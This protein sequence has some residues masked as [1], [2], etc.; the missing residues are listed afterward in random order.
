[1]ND[2]ML[3]SQKSHPA[4]QRISDLAKHSS[5]PGKLA[6]I[7]DPIPL[8]QA[9]K[10]GLHFVGVYLSEGLS[11]PAE[12][13]QL[14][15]KAG[16]QPQPI[17]AELT[18]ELFRSDKRPDIFGIAKTPP[19]VRAKDFAGLQRDLLILDGVRIAGN[20][21]AI[22]RSAYALGA[23][24]VILVESGIKSITDRRLI[25]ASRGYIFSLPHALM[26]WG[27]VSNLLQE[28]GLRTVG[29]AAR[30]DQPIS[31]L[32]RHQEPLALLMGSETEGLSAE[33]L[34]LCQQSAHIPMNPAV[35]SL[36]VS[37]AA[38]ILLQ[39]RAQRNLSL[40]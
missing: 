12:L 27:Q 19:P 15:Q 31:Q 34:A 2:Q 13:Q 37:V 22:A 32:S 39:A 33:G 11:L 23:G 21:G 5:S 28:K 36:N 14:C 18:K 10:A 7:E 26:T 16:L 24:G 4:A 40:L 9:L 17:S 6:L 29:L 1:M 25:R 35:D 20:I 3:I 8:L 30:A 38:A